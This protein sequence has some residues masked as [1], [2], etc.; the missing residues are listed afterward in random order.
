MTTTAETRR[1]PRGSLVVLIVLVALWAAWLLWFTTAPDT[2]PGG[3]CSG[4]G[5]GCT[6]T[7]HDL[8]A[9]AGAIVVA[10]LSALVVAVTLVVRVVRIGRGSPRTTWDVLLG[11]LLLLVGV[12]WLIGTVAGSF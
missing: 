5:F 7:P 10:P 2:N 1:R 9:F 11:A 12:L 3:Q 6:L 4:L 8:A